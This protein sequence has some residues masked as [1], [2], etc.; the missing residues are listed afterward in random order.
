M[1]PSDAWRTLGAGARIWYKV[2]KG[3]EHIDVFLE[4]KPLDGLS[5]EVYA[6]DQLDKPIGN[7][8]Y[9]AATKRLVWSGGHWQSEGAWLGRVTNGNSVPVQYKL[10][11][12]VQDISNKSC[13]SYWEYIGTSQ[14]Y[15]TKCE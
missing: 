15:W 7:G 11:S 3:G 5:L 1:T 8:T 4:G 2:G 9:Q 12:S 10:S 14:V 6:P 13:Y